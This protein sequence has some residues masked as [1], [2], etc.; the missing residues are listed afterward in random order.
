MLMEV[1]TVSNWQMHTKANL[2]HGHP[3]LGALMTQ[4]HA[5]I[6]DTPDSWPHPIL[7]RTQHTYI[8]LLFME[9]TKLYIDV[10]HDPTFGCPLL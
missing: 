5:Q 3:G 9:T 8:H 10:I 4:G 2:T 7:R 6:T 1:D